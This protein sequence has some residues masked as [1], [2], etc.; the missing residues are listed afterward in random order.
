MASRPNPLG[1]MEDIILVDIL[2]VMASCLPVILSIANSLTGSF[3][4][5]L[6]SMPTLDTENLEDALCL[7]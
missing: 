3:F 5:S 7:L 6:P 4:L 2:L 1:F